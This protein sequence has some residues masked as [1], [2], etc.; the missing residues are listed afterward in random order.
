MAERSLSE[1]IQDV[2]FVVSEPDRDLTDTP[3]YSGDGDK[4]RG[5]QPICYYHERPLFDPNQVV[6]VSSLTRG[7]ILRVKDA[8]YP[9]FGAIVLHGPVQNRSGKLEIRIKTQ[10]Q[11]VHVC[12]LADYSVVGYSPKTWSY[13]RYF[14]DTG[15]VAPRYLRH[16]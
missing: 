12:H 13:H 6:L 2:D 15:R 7:M 3:E 11:L 14:I 5:F 8:Y 16:R 4:R 1:M 9:D 10:D